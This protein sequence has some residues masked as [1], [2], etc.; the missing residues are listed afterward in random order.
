[1]IDVIMPATT[2]GK[3][4]VFSLGSETNIILESFIY[5]YIYYKLPDYNL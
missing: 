2:F 5:I 1:M 3:I 4:D